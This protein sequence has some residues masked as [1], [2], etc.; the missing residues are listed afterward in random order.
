MHI[1]F[2]GHLLKERLRTLDKRLQEC[3]RLLRFS[4]HETLN[5]EQGGGLVRAQIREEGRLLAEPV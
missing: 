3:M 2:H 5:N 4:L 1:I